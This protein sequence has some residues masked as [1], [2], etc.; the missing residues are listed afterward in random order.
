MI[1]RA[2]LPQ[3]KKF[4]VYLMLPIIFTAIRRTEEIRHLIWW[5]AAAASVSGLWSFVQFWTNRQNALSTEQR[6]LSALR[7]RPG[8]GLH[9]PLDDVRRGTDDGLICCCCLAPVRAA[10]PI[11]MAGVRG[12]RS[13][14]R[15]DRDRMDAK[16]VAWSRHRCVYLVAVWRPKYLLLTPLLLIVGW[17]VAPR[18]VRARVIS[19]YQPHGDFDSNLHRN[20]TAGSASK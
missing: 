4:F 2:G 17:F 1:P 3:V 15:L 5:W 9:E 13:D 19:I 8:D 12:G 7:G 10:A 16:R 6:F 18:S 20:I 11:P 14:F